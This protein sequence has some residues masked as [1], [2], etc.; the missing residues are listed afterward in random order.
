[1][2]HLEQEL[3]E[4]KGR[5]ERIEEALEQL[6]KEDLQR[7]NITDPDCARMH[8]RQ[9]SH[10]GYNTQAVFDEQHGL[11]VNTDVTNDNND[12]KQFVEQITAAQEVTGKVPDVAGA[13]SGYYSGGELDKMAEVAPQVLVPAREQV[14][15]SKGKP[16]A[17]GRFT[18]LADENVYVCPA[19]HRLPYRRTCESRSCHEYQ[20]DGGTCCACPHYQQCTRGRNGR[21]IVRY[22][23]EDLRDR[24]RQQFAQPANQEIYK[25]RKETAELPFGHIKRNLG[26]GH[27]LL[28]GLS[29][30]RAETSV[31]ASCFNVARLIGLF[32]V[33]GLIARLSAL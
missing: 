23:N 22:F 10:A 31:L 30:A 18:Y 26:A 1:M 16:F 21:K 27:F 28:R 12:R 11:I 4:Q 5:K 2:V 19:G 13:D 14:H 3:A 6:K 29:G 32:G 9:G 8:G 24:L 20:L 17:K 7:V 15:P 33:A 25:R